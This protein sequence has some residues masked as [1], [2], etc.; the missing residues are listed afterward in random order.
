MLNQYF[1]SVIDQDTAPVVIC[2]VNCTILYMNPSAISRYKADLTGKNLKDCHNQHSN[3]MIDQVVAWFQQS[4]AHN[5]VYTYH[6]EK[7]Q[8]DVY[9]VALRD[10][11]GS[12]IGFYEKHEYR[13]AETMKIY[14]IGGNENA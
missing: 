8:R 12:L 3:H 14:D 11:C 6:K 5:I 2:N 13:K 1:K 10:D 7:D 4:T 9:M